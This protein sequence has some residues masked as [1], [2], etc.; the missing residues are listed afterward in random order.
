[1][2]HVLWRGGLG[3]RI[4]IITGLIL[5]L[6][7]TLHV[8]NLAVVL[9]SPTAFDTVQAARLWVIRSNVGTA[10]IMGSLVTHMA[11][12]LA[13]VVVARGLRMPVTDWVQVVLGL[14]IPLMLVDHLVYTRGAHEM[15]G[16]TTML[17]YVNRLIWGTSDGWA[18]AALLCVAWVHGAIGLHMWLRM[19]AWWTRA[20]PWLIGV[21]VMLPTLGLM[22]YVTSARVIDGLLSDPRAQAVAHRA[23]NW[24][25]AAGFET[26]AQSARNMTYGVWVVLGVAATAFVLRRVVAA[27]A[28]PIRV[29]YVDGPS[30]RAPRGQTILET[31][32]ASGVPHTALC[33]GRG[34]C[35][36]CRVIVEEGLHDLPPPSE[37][38]RKSLAAVGA[39]PN[40]RLACQVRPSGPVRVFRVF[41][42]DGKKGRAHASQGKEARLA[43]LFLDMRGFT[44]RT[45]G[46]LPYDVVFLLNRFFDRIVPPIVAAGGT[47]DKYMGDGLMAVFETETE[48]ASARAAIAAVGGIGAALK[49]F[50]ETL[51]TEG[52]AP[53]SIGIGVHLGTV[54][55]GEIGAA[56]QAPRTLIGDTVNFAARLEGETKP[57]AVQALL[58]IDTLEAAGAT[59]P[60]DAMVSLTLRGREAPLRALP[61]PDASDLSMLGRDAAPNMR[62]VTA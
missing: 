51:A 53:V 25:D 5:M 42:R 31:S 15:L 26:L 4:R 12:S 47:V 41:D 21:A 39:P 33:G 37:A 3:T 6:Y 9:I 1:M 38:E 58:S 43:V 11:L 40:A 16:V 44:A 10:V 36:T 28:K 57:R 13:K 46:Q 2:T 18:Q 27:I 60:E 49:G 35:T 17:G 22:G 30:V 48:A 52:A 23:W 32:H 24:P 20:A 59:P 14:L 19:T 55:L 62:P 7:L 56:G 29:H 8:I 45:D 61:L 54:V 50:N 34:R